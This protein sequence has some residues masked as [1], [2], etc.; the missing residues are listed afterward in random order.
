MEKHEPHGTTLI[1]HSVVIHPKYRRQG[2]ATAMLTFYL[3]RMKENLRISRIF[4]IAKGNLLGFY[5]SVGFKVLRLSPVVHG[6]DPW[7]ELS[8]DLIEKRRVFQY[9]VDAFTSKSRVFSFSGTAVGVVLKHYSDET[10]QQLATENN[11]SVTTFIERIEFCSSS[12]LSSSSLS[13]NA[14]AS[15]P[16]FFIR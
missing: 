10:M 16:A 14:N 8:I 7:F 13:K 12:S 9:H 5:T 3:E 2:L 15:V 6:K 11:F 4:I 1:I